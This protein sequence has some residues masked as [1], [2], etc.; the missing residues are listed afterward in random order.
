M[1][2]LSPINGGVPTKL[3]ICA[4]RDLQF[5]V[6]SSFPV[7]SVAESASLVKSNLDLNFLSILSEM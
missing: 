1:T 3:V 5:V 2:D 7:S 6:M 4:S